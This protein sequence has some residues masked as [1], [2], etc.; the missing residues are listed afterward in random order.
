MLFPI[1]Y[2]L[3]IATVACNNGNDLSESSCL[4]E[5]QLLVEFKTADGTEIRIYENGDAYRFLNNECEF[6]GQYFE[7]DFFDRSYLRTGEGVSIRVGNE[8]FPAFRAFEEDFENQEDDLDFIIQ[9]IEQVDRAFNAFTLQSPSAKTV[10]DYVQ[11]RKCILEGSCDFI[12][13]RFDVIDDPV[14]PGNSVLQFFA[15]APAADMVTSKTSISTG[16][17]FF[18]QGDEFWFEADYFIDG[19][20]PTT[21]ADFES[22]FFTESPGP[23]LIF[24]SGYLAVENKFN[25]KLNYNQTIA[26]PVIFPKGQ[27]VNVRIKIYYDPQNG[28]FKVWQDQQLIIDTPAQSMPFDIWVQDNLEVGI[29]ATNQETIVMVDNIRFSDQPLD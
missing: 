24:R 25:E 16:L 28:Y 11:L 15:V 9:N 6:I 5:S 2:L 27:W 10:E 19:H 26:E 20:Y 14:N 21:I 17:V 8:L 3:F 13:N 18:E 23:R 22:S 7:P 29:T 12:D 4:L 1:S